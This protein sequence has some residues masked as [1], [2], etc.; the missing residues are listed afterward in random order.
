VQHVATPR[1]TLQ[2]APPRNSA[3][4][5]QVAAVDA[6]RRQYRALD[7]VHE[8]LSKNYEVRLCRVV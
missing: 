8:K 4:V 5:R 1:S 6:K 2:Q 7:D 3:G